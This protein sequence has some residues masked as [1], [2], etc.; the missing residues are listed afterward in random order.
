MK[1]IT[2]EDFYRFIK[3][4]NSVKIEDNLIEIGAQKQIKP[5]N[6]RISYRKQNSLVIFKR[7]DWATHYL[8]SEYRKA[9][10]TGA[11]NLIL[12]I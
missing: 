6:I 4:H 8:N 2:L 1:E 11:I 9:V 7:G 12:G 10:T 3:T 5:Q